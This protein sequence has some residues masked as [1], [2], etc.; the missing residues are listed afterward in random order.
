MYASFHCVSNFRLQSWTTFYA[1]EHEHISFFRPPSFRL[2][3]VRVVQPVLIGKKAVG[4]NERPLV[5][6]SHLNLKVFS[7]RNCKHILCRYHG[8]GHN[9]D[10]FELKIIGCHLLHATYV[11]E[12]VHGVKHKQILRQIVTV[13]GNVESI[14]SVH[15]GLKICLPFRQPQCVFVDGFA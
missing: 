3:L 10:L 6:F 14:Q 12:I 5:Q 11:I 13:D 15:D 8:L 7:R 2:H 9:P 1:L 4:C